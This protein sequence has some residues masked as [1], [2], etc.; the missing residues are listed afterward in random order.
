M[1]HFL[2]PIFAI[3]ASVMAVIPSKLMSQQ[4]KNP[5]EN[6]E[7]FELFQT[8]DAPCSQFAKNI[9]LRTVL[10]N[11]AAEHGIAIWIDRNVNSDLPISIMSDDN[12]NV[13]TLLEKLATQCECELAYL[14]QIIYFAPR[15]QADDIEFA[16]W[17]LYFLSEGTRGNQRLDEWKW[18]SVIEPSKLIADRSQQLKM[19]LNQLESI[20][21]D[22]WNPSSIPASDFA[23]QWTSILAGFS[24]T[25]RGK[26]PDS[27]NLEP[28]ATPETVRFTYPARYMK[29]VGKTQFQAWKTKW[30]DATTKRV[31]PD[32][33]EIKAPVAAHRQFIRMANAVEIGKVVKARVKA[34]KNISKEIG[35][36]RFT[37]NAKGSLG[38]ILSAVKQQAPIEIQPWPLPASIESRRAELELIQVS[39]DTLLQSVAIQTQTEI[40]RSGKQ[41]TVKLPEVK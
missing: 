8:L 20:E 5:Y 21:H 34:Q 39:L 4:V 25:I 24:T 3:F 2:L 35:V 29:S 30:F 22:L 19:R 36:L 37:I 15:S 33:W 40:V 10:A 9:S 16:Y 13:A 32:S 7:S 11:I 12:T 18:P 38:A 28:Y 17:Q 41:V 23:A 6:I 26:F 14:N 31:E 1:T 27:L